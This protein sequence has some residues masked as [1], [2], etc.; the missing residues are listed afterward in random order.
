MRVSRRRLKVILWLVVSTQIDSVP[1]SS[2]A[3]L[4]RR[5]LQQSAEIGL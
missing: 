3:P 2:W 5:L 4:G 1:R